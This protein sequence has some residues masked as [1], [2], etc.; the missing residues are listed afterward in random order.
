[1]SDEIAVCMPGVGVSSAQSSPMP[2]VARPDAR[3]TL[4]VLFDQVEFGEHA[5]LYRGGD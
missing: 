5:P 3:G 1:M 4:E 2:S